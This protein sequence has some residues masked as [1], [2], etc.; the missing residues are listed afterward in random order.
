M[1]ADFPAAV[2]EAAGEEAGRT[3]MDI[4]KP[5]FTEEEY[6]QHFEAKEKALQDVLESKCD[7]IGYAKIPFQIGGNVDLYCYSL[8]DQGTA[9]VTMELIKP[10]GS[11][12]IPNKTGTFELIA[13]T[14]KK[15]SDGGQ[16]FL[17]E[18]IVRFSNIFTMLGEYSSVNNVE[19]GDTCEIPLE[20]E[21]ICLLFDEYKNNEKKFVVN[22]QEHGLLL[23]IEVFRSEMEYAMEHGSDELI[24]YLKLLNHYPFS[25][26]DREPVV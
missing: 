2:L 9:L 19:P 4:E 6:K 8:T 14:R 16:Q 13:C 21:D 12:P 20:D 11:G 1:A 22:G 24:F 7:L 15:D 5:K 3:S 25:G 10:D 17:E 18:V 23:C 26:L